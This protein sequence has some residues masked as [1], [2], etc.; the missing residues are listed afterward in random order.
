MIAEKGVKPCSR[1]GQAKALDQFHKNRGKASGYDSRCKACKYTSEERESHN[2]RTR[3]HKFL[4]RYGIT[5][6]ERDRMAADQD[7]KCAICGD[8]ELL[9]VDHCHAS[10]KVRGLICFRCNTLLGNAKDDPDILRA[11]IAYLEVNNAGENSGP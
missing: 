6:T 11:A 8:V 9:H 5:R 10:G 4:V 2:Q 7:G 3:D 1:C